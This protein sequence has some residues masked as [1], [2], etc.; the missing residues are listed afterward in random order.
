MT[1]VLCSILEKLL[2]NTCLLL[3]G[4]FC[5][6]KGYLTNDFIGWIFVSVIVIHNVTY[7]GLCVLTPEVFP[8]NNDG[9]GLYLVTETWLF[10]FP[11][12]PIQRE[13]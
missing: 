2:H 5:S 4:A 7:I 3:V 13:K 11:C 10:H 1:R 8:T 9:S 6:S 12:I